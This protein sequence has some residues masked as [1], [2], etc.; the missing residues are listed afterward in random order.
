[1]QI[2]VSKKYPSQFKIMLNEPHFLSRGI[3][4]PWM[5]VINLFWTLDEVRD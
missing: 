4:N 2:L 5:G 1:M 3:W